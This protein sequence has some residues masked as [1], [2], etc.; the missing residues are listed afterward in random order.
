[1]AAEAGGGSGRP[2]L[3]WL[4]ITRAYNRGMSYEYANTARDFA[5]V[6]AV[7][8]A[9]SWPLCI[10]YGDKIWVLQRPDET[11]LCVDHRVAERR[12]ATCY[13]VALLGG[14]I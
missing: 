14:V 9:A 7:L 4:S 13:V 10:L 3:A 12:G 6:A 11:H 8:D 5:I 2:A 1:M